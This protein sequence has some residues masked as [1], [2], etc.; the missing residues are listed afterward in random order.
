MR[1][2][3]LILETELDPIWDAEA[4]FRVNLNKNQIST[5]I[6]VLEVFFEVPFIFD[7][8]DCEFFSRA[9]AGL[10]ALENMRTAL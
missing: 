6:E 5:I 1:L 3:E 7:E 2:F 9:D 4:G 8:I 10:E